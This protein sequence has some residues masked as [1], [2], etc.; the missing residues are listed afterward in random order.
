MPGFYFASIVINIVGII[1]LWD[2]FGFTLKRCA[3][4]SLFF[5]YGIELYWQCEI[6]QVYWWLVW[7]TD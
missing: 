1:I 7:R 2:F 5:E 3:V 4:F 6:M